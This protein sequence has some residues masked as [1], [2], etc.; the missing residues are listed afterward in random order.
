MNQPPR[1]LLAMILPRVA[2]MLL[3][4]VLIGITIAAALVHRL[5]HFNRQRRLLA[6]ARQWQM[7]YTPRDIF[8]L[9]PRIGA[10]VPV[11][12]AADVHV[13]DVIYG[14]ETGGHRYIFCAEYTVGVVR[15]KKRRRSV[16]SVLE[17]RQRTDGAMWTSSRLAMADVPLIDQYRSLGA[18]AGDVKDE[19][20]RG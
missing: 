5:I 20:V 8:N 6:L 2:P 17:P 11:P 14:T 19:R 13:S 7:Q 9:A 1:E 12:G 18:P 10:L 16:I 4:G 15:A 3:L